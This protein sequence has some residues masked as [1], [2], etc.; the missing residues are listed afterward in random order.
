MEQC[1]GGHE[2]PLIAVNS[3]QKAKKQNIFAGEKS[4]IKE[5]VMQIPLAPKTLQCF[6]G[7]EGNITKG[8]G[9]GLLHLALAYTRKNLFNKAFVG[10]KN[11]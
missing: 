1:G 6:I 7:G 2:Y 5:G 8:R 4:H 10:Y 9:A 3:E 11:C